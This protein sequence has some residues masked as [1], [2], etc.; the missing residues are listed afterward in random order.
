MPLNMN[1][2]PEPGD[3]YIG[4]SRPFHVFVCTSADWREWLSMTLTEK[5]Q[6]PTRELILMPTPTRFSWVT[7]TGLKGFKKTV[8][9]RLGTRGDSADVH[10]GIIL[11]QEGFPLTAP[12]LPVA[13]PSTS[14]PVKTTK[15]NP[16]LSE[17]GSDDAIGDSD[18]DMHLDADDARQEDI[19]DIPID[20]EP[21]E[22]S[23]VNIKVDTNSDIGEVLSLA[24]RR[25]AMQIAN[26]EIHELMCES[27]G[28]SPCSPLLTTIQIFADGSEIF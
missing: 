3:I 10:V 16:P 8:A 28:E 19:F 12:S 2:A 14:G 23:D 9:N 11:T 24:A 15:P 7:K 22:F 25:E 21:E 4:L 1:P 18:V 20:A 26:K 6:H 13:Q 17:L 5:C 27:P